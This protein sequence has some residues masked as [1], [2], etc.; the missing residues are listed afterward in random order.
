MSFDNKYNTKLSILYSNN[1]GT[2]AKFYI[3]I[4][5]KQLTASAR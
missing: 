3:G 5:Y 1:Q 2:T 4:R